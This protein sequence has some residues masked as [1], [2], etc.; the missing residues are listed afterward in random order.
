ML[1]DARQRG[2]I[3]EQVQLRLAHCYDTNLPARRIGAPLWLRPRA[4]LPL[5]LARSAGGPRIITEPHLHGRRRP[6]LDVAQQILHRRAGPAVI[7]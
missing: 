5:H 2:P 6:V 1:S 3:C 4:H 7:K